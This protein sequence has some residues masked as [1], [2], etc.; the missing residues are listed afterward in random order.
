[1]PLLQRAQRR[2]GELP[3]RALPVLASRVPRLLHLYPATLCPHIGSH[4]FDKATSV[5]G[6]AKAAAVGIAYSISS[7]MIS[8]VADKNS[9]T[10][11]S[12]VASQNTGSRHN[13]E[14]AFLERPGKEVS[15]NAEVESSPVVAV[16]MTKAGPCG[17]VT[18]SI[19]L[20]AG[21]RR[22]EP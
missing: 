8:G 5:V 17:V 14:H 9:A 22:P 10:A 19:L 18:C 7:S 13:I 4:L 16:R 3:H 12:A 11:S 1:M 21:E 2:L 20:S 15:C 6:G